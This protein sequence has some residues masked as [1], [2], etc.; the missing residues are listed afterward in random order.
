MATL[1]KNSQVSFKSNTAL[2]KKARKVFA[3]Q[4]LNLTEVMNEFLEYVVQTRAIPFKTNTDKKRE[5]MI[6]DLKSQ[7]DKSFA[8]YEAGHVVSQEEMKARYGL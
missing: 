6:A 4:D 5:Q 8:S 1:E 7:I 2:V 3:E